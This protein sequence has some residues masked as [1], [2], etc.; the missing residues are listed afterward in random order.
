M[1]TISESV[2]GKKYARRFVGFVDREFR[3][4]HIDDVIKD[5]IDKHNTIDRLIWSRGHSIENYYFDLSTLRRPLRNF[6]TTPF[7]D[8]ALDLFEQCL[9]QTIE[10]ACAVGLAASEC[11]MLQS[12]KSSIDWKVLEFNNSEL[13]VN[14]GIWLS[15]L[16]SK[17]KVRTEDAHLLVE[18]FQ[19]WFTKVSVT[20]FKIVRWLCHGHIGVTVIW[21]AYARCVFEVCRRLGSEDPQGEA[22]NVLRANETVRCNGCASEWAQQALNRSC[23]YPEEIFALLDL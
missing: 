7:F 21:A 4:F 18:T 20:D 8:D 12:V 2:N 19:S 5:D 9:E 10:I 3:G 6:S 16:V 15:V 1:E 23:E 22:R 14:T 17:K 13:I 11:G